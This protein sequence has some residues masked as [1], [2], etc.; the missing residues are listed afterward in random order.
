MDQYLSTYDSMASEL[1]RLRSDLDRMRNERDALFTATA[2][3]IQRYWGDGVPGDSLSTI[4]AA[5][6]VIDRIEAGATP[7]H[8]ELEALTAKNALLAASLKQCET[9]NAQLLEALQ[10]A[11]A[12]SEALESK[13]Y[14][15]E[16]TTQTLYLQAKAAIAAAKT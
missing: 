13:G 7:F 12:H 2:N 14:V 5:Q 11:T 15:R 16:K 10:A 3:L 4:V 6:D 8:A 1:Q 9:V